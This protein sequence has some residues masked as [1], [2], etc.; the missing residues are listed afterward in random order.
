MAFGLSSLISLPT[1]P[2]SRLYALMFLALSKMRVNFFV[3]RRMV[4]IANVMGYLR[5]RMI[6]AHPSKVLSGPLSFVS[7]GFSS[8]VSTLII[9]GLNFGK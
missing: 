5:L 1:N 4:R 9:I 8:S 3:P 2:L 6:S 7:F